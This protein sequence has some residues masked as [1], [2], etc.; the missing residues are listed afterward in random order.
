[1]FAPDLGPNVY[2]ACVV[3]KFRLIFVLILFNAHHSQSAS[4]AGL[5]YVSPPPV[6]RGILT[7]QTS[8]HL[9][10]LNFYGQYGARLS[11]NQ[12]VHGETEQKRTLL[13]SLISPF[14]YNAP[15]V[16]LRSLEQLFIDGTIN[17]LPWGE[18]IGK[19]LSDWQEFILYVRLS[20]SLLCRRSTVYLS[21]C[22]Q[23]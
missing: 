22:R 14:L 21:A 19:M 16:H 17:R 6:R 13:I 20:I 5:Q 2:T 8:V 1:M 11:R 10:F 18:F 23:L 12:S 4:H 9:R 7:Y 3:G 15:D